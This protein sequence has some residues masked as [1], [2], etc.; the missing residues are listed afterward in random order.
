MN[1]ASASRAE[2]RRILV[3]DAPVRVFHWL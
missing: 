2:T 1:T 3:W